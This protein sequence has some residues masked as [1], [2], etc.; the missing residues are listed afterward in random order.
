MNDLGLFFGEIWHLLD[1]APV[2]TAGQMNRTV[3]AWGDRMERAKRMLVQAQAAAV[4]MHFALRK[5]AEELCQLRAQA[6]AWES[7]VETVTLNNPY[8]LAAF[9]PVTEA[10]WKRLNDLIQR[11]LGHGLDR[12]SAACMMHAWDACAA[13]VAT[14]ATE[15]I[16]AIE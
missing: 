13:A 9:T 3:T 8:G 7:A 14:L 2:P 16:E 6:A 1:D 15:T 4:G 11:E 5:Q 10:D 12:Y